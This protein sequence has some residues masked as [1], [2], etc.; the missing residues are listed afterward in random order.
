MKSQLFPNP[1]DSNDHHKA[2]R[3]ITT[4]LLWRCGLEGR[5]GGGGRLSGLCCCKGHFFLSCIVLDRVWKSKVTGLGPLPRVQR[6][7]VSQPAIR[8]SFS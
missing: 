2:S 4:N 1:R 6:K 7:S 8:A 3:S 5:E